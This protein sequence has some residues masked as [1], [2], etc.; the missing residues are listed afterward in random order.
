MSCDD[1][2]VV[3]VRR[4]P[5]LLRHVLLCMLCCIMVVHCRASWSVYLLISAQCSSVVELCCVE[6][7][8]GV[9]YALVVIL[10]L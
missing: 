1:L 7:Q 3:W 6:V 10:G 5:A 9:Y 8:H 4:S 2:S